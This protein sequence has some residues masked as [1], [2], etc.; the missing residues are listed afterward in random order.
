MQTEKVYLGET[1]IDIDTQIDLAEH[2]LISAINHLNELLAKRNALL[3]AHYDAQAHAHADMEWGKAVVE[4]DKHERE[5]A[6]VL[7]N[8]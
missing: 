4:S 7:N 5:I 6:E 3:D 2:A 1:E 8:V